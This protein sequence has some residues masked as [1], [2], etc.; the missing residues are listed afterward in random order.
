MALEEEI[1]EK[2][3]DKT[4]PKYKQI[5]KRCASFL[6]EYGEVFE[7]THAA[8]TSAR[9]KKPIAVV[10]KKRAAPP[11]VR[12]D[13]DED[14][15]AEKPK[16]SKRAKKE[17]GVKK[18]SQAGGG[19]MTDHDMAE[20]NDRGRISKQTVAVLKEF[21]KARGESTAGKKD[22]LVERV[23]GYLEGKGL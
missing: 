22:E 9:Y 7:E 15:D 23:Q 19:G 11:V 16:P 18:E 4:I 1:P 3:D 5:D 13:D 21:L 14:D 10:G 17:V 6:A 8:L 2:P 20:L 12:D